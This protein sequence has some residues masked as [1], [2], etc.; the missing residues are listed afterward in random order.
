M[1]SLLDDIAVDCMFGGNGTLGRSTMCITLYNTCRM[2][3]SNYLGKSQSHRWLQSLQLWKIAGWNCSDVILL[4][5]ESRP[6]QY[7][8]PQSQA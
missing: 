3:V 7:S 4:A 1:A 5:E 8:H 6:L 2:D